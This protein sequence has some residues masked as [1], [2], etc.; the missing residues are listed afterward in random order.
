MS[1]LILIIVISPRRKKIDFKIWSS[2]SRIMIPINAKWEYEAQKWTGKVINK[3]NRA[4][5]F[6][7]CENIWI[8]MNF[9][10]ATIFILISQSKFQC[11]SRI[12][13][14][15]ESSSLWFGCCWS[16]RQLKANLQFHVDVLA[17]LTPSHRISVYSRTERNN[18]LLSVH[19]TE[20][21]M[22][23]SLCEWKETI[24]DHSKQCPCVR[25]YR[26]IV[27]E[28]NIGNEKK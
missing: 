28:I 15:F 6:Y 1:L 17:L 10:F 18:F 11:M 5:C 4:S 22:L 14:I 13:Y 19:I 27:L 21:Y 20:H 16:S 25:K 2:G 24:S 7:C 3:N 12:N 8:T 26:T 23:F 9:F